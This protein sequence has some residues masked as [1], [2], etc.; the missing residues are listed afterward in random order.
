VSFEYL[1]K[2]WYGEGGFEDKYKYMA[3]GFG[4]PH[5][6]GIDFGTASIKAVELSVKDGRPVLM[7]YGQASLADLEQG[8]APQ[9][10]SYD[11]EIAIHLKKLIEH[12]KPKSSDA[13][14][15]MPAFIGL[16]SL[17]EFPLLEES[18]L[19]DAVRFEA[20]KYIPSSLDEVALSWEVV[21]VQDIPGT[22]GKMEILLVAAL[23]KEVARYEQYVTGADFSLN[24]LELETFSIVRSIIGDEPGLNLIIDIGS[25]ATNLILVENGL[26]KVSRNLDVGGRDITR[27]L[28]ESLNI[29]EERAKVLKKSGKD[30]LGAP[31]SSLV[32]PALQMIVSEAERILASYRTKHSD[33]QCKNVILSG[34]TAKFPG[35]VQYYANA[36]KLPVILGD[37]WKNIDYDPRLAKE[38]EGFGSSFSVAL[39]L[40]LH[41]T[42]TILKKSDGAAGYTK[43]KKEFSLKALLTKKI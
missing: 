35:L 8:T 23:N 15:A 13:Y 16:I 38:I 19:Q 5:F 17:I 21:G 9:G 24:F 11:E 30:F 29:T 39:G 7:N 6:L 25:R 27:V 14:V 31:E 18:E 34:G 12:M 22:G 36:L 10:P 33:V 32:F 26:V 43:P 3:F 20:H 40:A 37:P 42:D 28:A 2:I 1:G 41:G 4:K